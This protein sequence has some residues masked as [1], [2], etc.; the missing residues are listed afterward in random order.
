MADITGLDP[1]SQATVGKEVTN[2]PDMTAN[3]LASYSLPLGNNDL[4]FSA[5]YRYQS[6]MYYTFVQE[7]A[8]RD[9][10]SDYSYLNARVQF[11]FGEEQ[12]FSVAAWGNNLTE[13]FSC[14]SVIW[15]PG[16]APG[17]NYSCE[18]SAYGEALYGVTLEANFGR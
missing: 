9:E 6:S 3:L 1:R 8:A 16:A 17:Q 13:E 10:S 15:G 11:S 12:R 4:T 5:N 14:S 18:V 2:T 7:A